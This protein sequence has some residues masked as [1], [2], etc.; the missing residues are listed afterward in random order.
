MR[1][2]R[3]QEESYIVQ[4]M[5]INFAVHTEGVSLGK[6]PV[7]T[8]TT[9]GK[10]IKVKVS[11]GSVTVDNITNA[12]PLL[13]LLG[14]TKDYNI[15]LDLFPSSSSVLVLMKMFLELHLLDKNRIIPAEFLVH[16]A[17]E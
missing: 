3:L 10:L 6:V 13:H 5:V 17:L 9:K 2:S 14:T 15:L 11:K 1:K 12:Q 7:L 16:H 8:T 4:A